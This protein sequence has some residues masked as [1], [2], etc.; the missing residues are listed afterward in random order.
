MDKPVEHTCTLPDGQTASRR[1]KHTYTHAIAVWDE[2]PNGGDPAHW[3][4]LSWH[5]SE[6][7]ARKTARHWSHVYPKFEIVLASRPRAPQADVLVRGQ[8]TICLFTALTSAARQVF[9][10][11]LSGAQTFDG[12]VVCEHRY[13]GDLSESLSAIDGLVLVHR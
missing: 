13:A 5:S 6:T 12:A 10:E 8:G 4:C 9:A 2:T 11:K 7:L 1:S 3:G